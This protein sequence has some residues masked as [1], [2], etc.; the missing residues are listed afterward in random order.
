M[1]YECFEEHT[2]HND[3]EFTITQHKQQM[4]ANVFWGWH[5]NSVVM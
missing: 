4:N 3:S 2:E 1:T 5:N